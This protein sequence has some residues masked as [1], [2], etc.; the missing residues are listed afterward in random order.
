MKH[1][2]WGCCLC[3]IA[4]VAGLAGGGGMGWAAESP[5][6]GRSS[7]WK[8]V[9]SDEF[10]AAGA[11]DPAKWGYEVGKLR[12]R[13][14][15]YYTRDRRENARV[16][17]GRLILEARK[18]AYEG[19]AD[20]TSASLITLGRAAWTHARVE[21]RAKL[22]RGRGVWPAIWMLGMNRDKVGW[23]ACG[24]IDIMEYVGF[25]PDTIHANVHMR[26][27]NHVK[28]TGR[29]S[30]LKVAE[31]YGAF[32]VYAMEWNKARMDFFVDDRLYFSFANEGAG[33]DVWPFDQPFYLILNVAIGGSWGGQRGIDD[34]IF[35]QRMEIDYV[36]VYER[37][38]G[39]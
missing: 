33:E 3:W 38:G 23:P 15:Q 16:E 2:G 20:Y 22:P 13:E 12:N 5:A 11:P 6:S 10:E 36:R 25:D 18:E 32:H 14:S 17:G 39:S 21:V 26:R 4:C 27:Y 8:L 29:G 1:V 31:P 30:K 35:P 7:S 9:W 24:E 37:Q 19:G 34:A 28:N